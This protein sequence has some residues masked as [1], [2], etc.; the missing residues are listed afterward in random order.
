M[1]ERAALVRPSRYFEGTLQAGRTPSSGCR[2]PRISP[3]ASLRGD[4]GRGRLKFFQLHNHQGLQDS[5]MLASIFRQ[6][7]LKKLDAKF[8]IPV[9]QN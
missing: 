4:I 8:Q 7:S 3:P 1:S 2:Q 6:A 5:H 9:S